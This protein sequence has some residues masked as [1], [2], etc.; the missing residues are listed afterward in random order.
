VR[1]KVTGSL[2][3]SVGEKMGGSTVR[4]R[5]VRGSFP[6]LKEE[7]RGGAHREGKNI[8]ESKKKGTNLEGGKDAP[9]KG[10]NIVSTKKNPSSEIRGEGY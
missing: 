3:E 7:Q 5:S 4:G 10:E 9:I 1:R 6:S 8:R 2:R